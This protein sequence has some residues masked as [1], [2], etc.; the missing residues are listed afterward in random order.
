MCSIQVTEMNITFP[1]YKSGLGQETP[2]KMF[3]IDF[4][5]QIPDNRKVEK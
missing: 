3:F 2:A 4:Y 5:F 1:K